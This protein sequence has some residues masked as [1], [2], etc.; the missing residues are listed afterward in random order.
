MKQPFASIGVDYWGPL[1]IT[2]SKNEL[3]K[4]Y[5]VLFTCTATRRVYLDKTE[6]MKAETFNLIFCRFFAVISVP[7][8]VISDNKTYFKALTE[9]FKKV[10]GDSCVTKSF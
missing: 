2:I 9:H 5:I 4:V 8:L 10:L 7:E 6:D 1:L 3:T